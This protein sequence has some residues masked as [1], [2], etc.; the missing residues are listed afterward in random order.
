MEAPMN[1]TTNIMSAEF[2]ANPYRYYAEMRRSQP[3]ARVEPGGMF[4]VSRYSDVAR[5][6]KSPEI[7]GQGF[8]AA[9]EPAWLPHNP[10]A[11]SVLALDGLDHARLRALVSGAFGPRAVSRLEPRVRALANDLTSELQTA[12]EADLI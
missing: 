9:W 11:R 12:G 1:E 10:L 2:R 3:V 7:F 4:A 6:M 8:R 5:I